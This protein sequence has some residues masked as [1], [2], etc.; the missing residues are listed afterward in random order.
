MRR[1]L[2]SAR[3]LCTTRSS[4]S[5]SGWRTALAIVLRTR[6]RAARDVKAVVA[7]RRPADGG[8]LGSVVSASRGGDMPGQYI[9]IRDRW[10]YFPDF[11][12]ER[13]TGHFV[14]S[15]GHQLG[16]PPYWS[17]TFTALMYGI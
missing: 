1:R 14:D 12:N 8:R 7:T 2:T 6:A 13:L 9:L 5:S 17:C 4:R 3:A 16:G 10:A 11:Q 15:D